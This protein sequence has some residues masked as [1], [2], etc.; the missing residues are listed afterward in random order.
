MGSTAELV[1]QILPSNQSFPLSTPDLSIVYTD[2]TCHQLPEAGK[3]F[4]NTQRSENSYKL[5]K[6][7]GEY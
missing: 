5:A 3:S 7:S 4:R 2:E 6:K 1:A